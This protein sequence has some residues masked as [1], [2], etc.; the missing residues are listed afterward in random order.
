MDSLTCQEPHLV[1]GFSTGVASNIIFSVVSHHNTAKWLVQITRWTDFILFYKYWHLG[2]RYPNVQWFYSICGYPLV[3]QHSYWKWWFIVDLPI[4]SGGFSIVFCMF[5]SG[6][7]PPIFHHF[8]VSSQPVSTPHCEAEN[9]HFVSRCSDLL[10]PK[11]DG[12]R[13]AIDEGISCISWKAVM[14]GLVWV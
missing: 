7:I 2:T 12:M 4:E 6:Y 13:W 9:F 1:E 5:T 10:E 14:P 11:G 3:I 8:F